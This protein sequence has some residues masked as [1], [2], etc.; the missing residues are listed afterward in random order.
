MNAM[1]RYMGVAILFSLFVAISSAKD[2][3]MVVVL[4]AA[5]VGHSE[6][7]AVRWR[8]SQRSI[9][10]VA[11]WF[12]DQRQQEGPS[13]DPPPAHVSAAIW[14]EFQ[15][16]IEKT[17]GTLVRSEVYFDQRNSTYQMT[18]S[19]FPHP[20]FFGYEQIALEIGDEFLSIAAETAAFRGYGMIGDLTVGGIHLNFPSKD[21]HDGQPS[22]RASTKSEIRA[23]NFSSLWSGNSKSS[24]Q[25]QTKLAK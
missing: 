13:F 14:R 11:N 15:L 20:S 3:K 1:K 4:E 22:G 5:P 19:F 8:K 12:I 25:C 17:D 24:P 2:L 16:E 23:H 21:S 6:I 10:V 9:D 18:G 7:K